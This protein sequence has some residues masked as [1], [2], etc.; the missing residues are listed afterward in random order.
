MLR[1]WTNDYAVYTSETCKCGRT[2][3]RSPGGIVGRHDD[4]V[5]YRGAKF[6]PVQVER[7]VR[8]LVELGDE[9]I[10]EMTCDEHIGTDIC[11]VVV[12]PLNEH[13]DRHVLNERLRALLREEL[14]V[15]P[16]TRLVPFGTLE[17]T[18]FK[19]KRIFDKRKM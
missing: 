4:M 7:V 19:A 18:T 5:I 11:T 13:V 2:L 16:E 10:I 17:R 15:T 8:N 14:L 12:E 1:Y 6:Y 3:G 9:F